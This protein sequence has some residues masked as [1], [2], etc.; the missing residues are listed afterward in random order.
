MQTLRILFLFIV[1]SL[2]GVI[3][4]C[5]IR[6]EDSATSLAVSPA[7]IED[8]VKPGSD[9]DQTISIVNLTDIP[10]PIKATPRN[11]IPN[12]GVEGVSSTAF[13]ASAWFK[14]EPADF[15]LQPKQEMSVKVTITA[16]ADTEPG[17]HYATVYFE[18]LIPQSA[19]SPTSSISL[20]R[21]GVLAFL[22]APGDIHEKLD[23]THSSL[24]K[25][26]MTGPVPFS[27]EL[28]NKGN[29]HTMP[30]AVF[31][32]D[33]MFGQKVGELMLPH[34]TILPG[35]KR[36]FEMEWEKKILFGPYTIHG[37]IV[38]GPN[39]EKVTLSKETVWIVPIHILTLAIVLL[40]SLVYFVIVGHKRI[41]LAF[42]VLTGKVDIASKNKN[43]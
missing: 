11:F 8:I 2:I 20:A 13:D 39:G 15:I 27:L 38:Y 41:S 23:I 7:V 9:V 30:S 6:A 21:V 42:S 5:Q 26:Q 18:P 17:G 12:E 3:S 24:R 40:T 4:P 31:A 14:I 19:V 28:E 29:I 33:N 34:L 43:T 25:W 22:I 32:I 10:L 35:T 1:I 36:T 16:P 37:D